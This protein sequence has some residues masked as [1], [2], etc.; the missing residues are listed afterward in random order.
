M[1]LDRIST[2]AAELAA[3][4]GVR[5]PRV[6]VGSVPQ[7]V[8]WRLRYSVRKREPVLTI[9]A[10]FGDLPV[11]E[12][13]AALANMIVVGHTYRAGAT[14]TALIFALCFVV[15]SWPLMYA[16]A[17]HGT[18]I[19]VTV[20]VFGTLYV[21]G[22]LLTFALRSRHVIHRS[23][24]RVAEVMGRSAVDSMI[25]HDIRN[26]HMIRGFIRLYLTA[27]SPTIAQ[28]MRRLDADFGPRP[29]AA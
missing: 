22:Y 5:T 16:A 15:A 17:Y 7:W 4:F 25:D 8:T 14:R 24:H 26:G 3:D 12:Q 19:E 2:R 13:D 23:D 1:D 28:R 29:I 11:S 9:A 27:F 20:S 18:P 6:V 10:G 21:F